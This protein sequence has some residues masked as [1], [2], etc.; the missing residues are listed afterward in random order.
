M[1][2]ELARAL[3]LHTFTTHVRELE[4]LLWQALATSRGGELELTDAVRR[5]VREVSKPSRE[6]TAEDV[7]QALARHN[8][9]KDKAWRELRLP[10]RHA[11]HRLMKKLNVAE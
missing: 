3:T 4:T 2:P 9:I 7:R 8:G 5:L 11:L 1:T 6:L 10:S